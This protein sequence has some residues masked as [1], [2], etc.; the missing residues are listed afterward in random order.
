MGTVLGLPP[1]LRGALGQGG[2]EG[3]RAVKQRVVIDDGEDGHCGCGKG[4]AAQ[5]VWTS[6]EERRAWL[7]VPHCEWTSAPAPCPKP[8]PLGP[9]FLA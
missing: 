3:A 4:Q 2:E 1:Q 9:K 6:P 5:L 7:P 8:K